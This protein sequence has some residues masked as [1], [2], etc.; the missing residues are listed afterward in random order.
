MARK[1]LKSRNVS[2]V[3]V[4]GKML[5][6]G[7]SITVKASAVGDRERKMESRGRIKILKSNKKDMVQIRAS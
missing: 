5:R 4:C 6:L 1:D 7:Q 3:S 2:S